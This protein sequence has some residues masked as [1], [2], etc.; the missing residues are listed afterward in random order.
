MK[1]F[2]NYD[3]DTVL[4]ADQPGPLVSRYEIY[5][6]GKL[7]EESTVKNMSIKAISKQAI[8]RWGYVK[9]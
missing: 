2:F 3:L 5:H 6:K 8:D 7:V 9:I 4:I 1:V